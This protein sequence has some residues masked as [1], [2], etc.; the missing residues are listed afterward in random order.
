MKKKI[1]ITLIVLGII[2][3]GGFGVKKYLSA[4]EVYPNMDSD[5]EV[6]QG[7]AGTKEGEAEHEAE[8]K[9]K[10]KPQK[11][12]TGYEVGER[13]PNVELTDIDGNTDNLYDLMEGKDKFIINLSAD[14]CSDSQREK[15]KL[16]Q[17]YPELE[18]ENIGIAVV[19][20]NLSKPEKDITTDIDQIKDY[21]TE[22]NF[23][24]P[25]YID[26]DDELQDNLNLS[27]VPTNIVL[28]K[29]AIIKG[30][31]EEIDMDNLL[32][33]NSEEFRK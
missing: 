30:H 27:S 9:A 33:E 11:I 15:D 14:W 24:F 17:V 18:K 10:P 23:V 8:D 6:C 32:L 25:T 5:T 19:Y 16:N 31:T 2:G 28:D 3:T 4:N 1:I 26:Y 13:F 12:K 21:L 7:E 29:N 20:V 22:S